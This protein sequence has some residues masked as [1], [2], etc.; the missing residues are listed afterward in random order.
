MVKK[1]AFSAT[2]KILVIVLVLGHG[3]PLSH[4][5]TVFNPANPTRANQ[6]MAITGPNYE[7]VIHGATSGGTSFFVDLF[8]ID[9]TTGSSSLVKTKDVSVPGVNGV[10][11]VAADHTNFLFTAKYIMRGSTVPGSPDDYEMHAV[12]NG[13]GPYYLPYWVKGTSYMFFGSNVQNSGEY[14]LF[15]VLTHTTTGVQT[16]RVSSKVRACGVFHGTNFLMGSEDGGSSRQIFDYTNGYDGSLSAGPVATHPKPPPNDD[17]GGFVSPA[18]GRG[19]YVVATYGTPKG[20]VTVK[21][22]DGAQKL[23]LD[24]DLAVSGN[25]WTITWIPDTDLVLGCNRD[26][27]IFIVDFMDENL[28]TPAIRFIKQRKVVIRK[29]EIRLFGRIKRW[30]LFILRMEEG[31]QSTKFW[32]LCPARSSA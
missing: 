22:V 7:Y 26:D 19:Y 31:L 32:I 15:R 2:S 11:F 30:R 23:K 6:G 28:S 5:F 20:I 9:W 1:A 25:I 21:D 16:Y 29:L 4:W 8:S 10:A 18:D 12:T 3:R 13:V 17:E 24:L 27:N 14:R